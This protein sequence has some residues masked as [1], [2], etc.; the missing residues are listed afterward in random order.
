MWETQEI[1]QQA[2]HCASSV[3]MVHSWLHVSVR[4]LHVYFVNEASFVHRDPEW[5]E[6]NGWKKEGQQ[7]TFHPDPLRARNP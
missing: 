2:D 3:T 6:V 4:M 7:A 1:N 5:I